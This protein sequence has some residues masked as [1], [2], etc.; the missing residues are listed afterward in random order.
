MPALPNSRN[1]TEE[2]YLVFERASDAK[3]EFFNG[4]IIDL[5]GTSV[6]HAQLV[7]NI[8]SLLY[9]QGRAHGC[10]T[11]TTD[12]RLRIGVG[13]TYTYPDIIVI[14]GTLEYSDRQQDTLL[15]PTV[16]MEVLSPSTEIIDRVRKF[17][18]YTSI[19]TLQE[20]LLVT[21]TSRQIEQ[22]VRQSDGRWLYAK[23]TAVDAQIAL[24]SLN[25]ILRLDDIYENVNFDADEF[26]T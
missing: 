16:I 6:N 21:Q 9:I 23:L 4:E 10:R 25:C 8:S 3:H 15:N 18:Q 1:M 7:Q 26:R 20:Y 2:E 24:P 13:N 19:P 22:Y 5:A 14:C 17:A 11:F 12:V